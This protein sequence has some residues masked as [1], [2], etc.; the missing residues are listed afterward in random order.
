MNITTP[1]SARPRDDLPWLRHRTTRT[2]APD[3]AVGSATIDDVDFLNGVT[4]P[5]QA[6]VPTAAPTSA[7]SGPPQPDADLDLS[8]TSDVPTNLAVQVDRPD[9]TQPRRSSS[10]DLSRPLPIPA[11]RAGTDPGSQRPDR[12]GQFRPARTRQGDPTILTTKEPVVTLTRMQ[13]GVGALTFQAACSASVGDLKIGCAYQLVSGLSSVIH[14]ANGLRIAPA[15]SRR[16]VIVAS[17]EPFESLTVDLAQSREVERLIIYAYSE[18]SSTLNWDGTLVL[19]TYGG[20][21]VEVPL[22]RD[23]AAGVLVPLSL[24]NIDGEFVLRAE[25]SGLLGSIREAATAFGFER[26]SWLDDQ[27]PLS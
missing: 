27:T 15:G 1:D 25:Q 7:H 23:A 13:S 12:G 22:R 4:R 16:P 8:T 24:Y 14:H 6:T 9:R 26:I 10:L 2:S 3:P 20:A 17:S 19:Q 5:S 21:H 18:S 11:S